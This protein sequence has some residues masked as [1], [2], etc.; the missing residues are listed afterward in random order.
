L[1]EMS[2][3]HEVCRIAQDRVGEEGCGRILEVGLEV[4]DDSGIEADN[5]L[6]WLEI[7]LTEPPF[8]TARPSLCRVPG[9]VLR[10]THLEVE[11]GDPED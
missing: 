5:L 4:G 9:D 10:V 8:R 7:L 6:F 3:A 11:D 1:H 2:L